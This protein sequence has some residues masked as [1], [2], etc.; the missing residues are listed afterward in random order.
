MKIEI[1]E[2][3]AEDEQKVVELVKSTVDHFKLNSL[4][5]GIEQ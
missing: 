1:T 5:M 3:E 2:I 4:T